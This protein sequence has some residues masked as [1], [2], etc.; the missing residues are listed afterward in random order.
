M[1]VHPNSTSTLFRENNKPSTNQIPNCSGRYSNWLPEQG[2]YNKLLKS[3]VHLQTVHS[4]KTRWRKETDSRSF[5]P[6]SFSSGSFLPPTLH[7]E[8]ERVS[9]SGKLGSQVRSERCLPSCTHQS[10]IS[11]IPSFPMGDE[12]LSVSSS[13]LWTLP[14][15]SSF[16][17]D[18]E[19]PSE[20]MQG[21]RNILPCV[22]RRLD[23][24]GR[25][26]REVQGEYLLY[27]EPPGKLGISD[28]S[29]QI[30]IGTL[31]GNNL[32]G[33]TLGYQR[34]SGLY[35]LGE[36]KGDFQPSK[37][38]TKLLGGN[39][40]NVGEASRSH[41]LCRL[42]FPTSESYEKDDRSSPGS[43]PLRSPQHHRDTPIC[44][45]DLDL[46]VE[47]RKS[48]L[49]VPVLISSSKC[50]CLDGC[51]RERMGRARS[52]GKLGSG[53]LGCLY[54]TS[55][56]ESKRN[57]SS[58][59]NPSIITDKTRFVSSSILRQRDYSPSPKEARFLKVSGCNL[60]SCGEYLHLPNE[61]HSNPSAQS[62]RETECLGRCTLSEHNLAGRVD[63]PGDG[64]GEAKED[65]SPYGSR[66]DGN[67]LQLHPG[68]VCLP[69]QSPISISMGHLVTGLEPVERSIFV[70]SSSS[71]TQS[72]EEPG[73]F[74][75]QNDPYLEGSQPSQSQLSRQSIVSSFPASATPTPTGEGGV[76][77]GSETFLFSM[78]RISFL[79]ATLNPKYGE[80]ITD[81]L[82]S[83][84]RAST[85][86][87]QEVAW[88]AFKEWLL[89]LEIDTSILSNNH[90][91]EFLIW[92]REFKKLGTTTIQNYKASLQ[93]PLKMAFNLDLTSWEFKELRNSLYLE[94][95]PNPPRVPAWDL[96][97][98][99]E[100]LK[101]PSYSSY[102]PENYRQLKKCIF[103]VALASGNRVSEL[104]AMYRTGLELINIFEP[105]FI[106]VMPGFLYKNQRLG[107]N[108]PNI[109][110]V[111]FLGGPP[112]LC[113][114][115]ALA[116][117]VS[118]SSNSRGPLFLNSKTN[119]PL[120]KST[121]SKI[122][123]DVIEEACPNCL[124][125]AHEIRK[126]AT[127]IAWSRGLPPEEITKRAFWRLSS[128]FIE[129]YLC[130][131]DVS[132]CVALNTF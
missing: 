22:S 3:L 43:S 28:Q 113:P 91:L 54:T 87:Q 10:G 79:R 30:S 116:S 35:S 110:I 65:V 128:I 76:G 32:V 24:L 49:S 45:S 100:L 37:G 94:R 15:P 131:K 72:F 21:K 38:D 92:L 106:P 19:L 82:L 36:K 89:V 120:H 2:S 7:K 127:S 39:E 71:S 5:K 111:P 70:S 132:N 109:Q 46:V 27:Q 41:D 126:F 67:S 57:E 25:F 99:L 130:G 16:S 125:R 108:P 96:N 42:C 101:S 107:R 47:S 88:R 69:I 97:K 118:L 85:T 44:Y 74:Q 9:S 117:Y 119:L 73:T 115:R 53:R 77:R 34:T 104:S 31:S 86:K 56:Y 60:V 52:M 63:S 75:R 51:L 64:Q 17:R 18:Y 93:L 11:T 123:C 78:D 81:R 102:P 4:P 8:S 124:P 55:S 112:E 105:I 61:G 26:Q 84:K 98:V 20:K 68:E 13:S 14:G 12:I 80:A 95:P 83:G 1:E 48:G 122:L 33:S 121:V 29:Q 40:E 50:P 114:V 90:I 66:P 129:R 6:E 62:S 59:F 103:L 58:E 23:H